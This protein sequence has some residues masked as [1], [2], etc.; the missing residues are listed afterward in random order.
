MAVKS[1]VALGSE[2]SG[3]TS[4]VSSSNT[5]VENVVTK[6]ISNVLSSDSVAKQLQEELKKQ[7]AKDGVKLPASVTGTSSIKDIVTTAV[8]NNNTNIQTAVKNATTD[9]SESGSTSQKVSDTSTV[10]INNAVNDAI[11]GLQDALA[12]VK[13]EDSSSTSHHS[14]APEVKINNAVNDAVQGLQDALTYV[15]NATTDKSEDNGTSHHST[16]PQSSVV[17]TIPDRSVVG[18]APDRTPQHNVVPTVPDRTIAAPGTLPSPISNNTDTVVNDSTTHHNV[19]PTVPYRTI[20]APGTLPSPIGNSTNTVVNTPPSTN[21]TPPTNT[22]PS[23][24]TT[25]IVTPNTDV[26][27]YVPTNS[28]AV[29]DFALAIM[30]AARGDVGSAIKPEYMDGKAPIKPELRTIDELANAYGI[31]YDYDSIYKLLNNSVEKE[32]DARYAKQKQSE[33]KYY[34]NITAAQST[35]LDTLARDRTNAVQTGVSKGM[36]AANALGAMLGITNQFA[37]NATDLTQERGNLAKEYGSALANAMVNADKTSNER[38]NVLLDIAKMLYGYDSEQ[39]V[40]DANTYD[41]IL[42]NN[43]ALQQAYMNNDAALKNALA[44]IYGTA[45]ANKISGD[46]TLGASKIAGD[47]NIE[48]AR[49][50]AQ[51][52]VNAAAENARAQ[53]AYNR[54][55]SDYVA[56]SNEQAKAQANYYNTLAN[57]TA[58]P[59]AN[60][61]GS[62]YIPQAD[63]TRSA[64]TDTTGNGAESTTQQYNTTKTPKPVGL[65]NSAPITQLF[66]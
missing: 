13:S 16:A 20:A 33:D 2:G 29:A 19:V 15:K 54:L 22:P 1:M 60:L 57:S 50:G 5:A 66:K 31:T 26:T 46:A 40:A 6:T 53:E 44:S 37:E 62:G 43:T 25:P 61:T 63:L 11:Q 28:N 14:A 56:A 41:T 32:Y 21:T 3:S 8:V 4:K 23:T 27:N 24:N 30:Q 12:Y 9:K 51:A 48:A 35:L 38:R 58:N 39:Y 36:Q 55:Y 59:Y 65:W 64:Y 17:P 45:A 18:T 10:K 49:L 52:T 47:A 34:D 7:A 42:T